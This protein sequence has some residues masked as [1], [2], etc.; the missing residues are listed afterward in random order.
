MSDEVKENVLINKAD[1]ICDIVYGHL[2]QSK[3]WV[4]NNIIIYIFFFIVL[5]FKGKYREQ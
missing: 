1:S 3:K 2:L 5:T 4:L